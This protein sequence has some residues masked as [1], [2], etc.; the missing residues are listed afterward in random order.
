MGRAD[1]DLLNANNTHLF[2]MSDFSHDGELQYLRDI[3]CVA[4]V[5]KSSD[6]RSA[7]PI[8]S[9]NRDAVEGKYDAPSAGRQTVQRDR[10]DPAP[11]IC[12]ARE[13]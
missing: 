3:I 7:L 4:T 6:L 10:R 12:T 5:R 2:V 8:R 1:V 11:S 9:E 13:A